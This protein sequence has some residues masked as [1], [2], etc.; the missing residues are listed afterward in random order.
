MKRVKNV[1]KEG[2]PFSHVSI[3]IPGPYIT[4][5]RLYD[6]LRG[7]LEKYKID[8]RYIELEITETSVIH[9]IENAI[10]AIRKF[11]EM[12][13][14]VALDD[15]GTGLSSLSYLKSMPIT[16]VKIDKSFVDG[17]PLSERD[18]AV[19]K[20]IVKLCYSLNLK[21]VIEG[22]ETDEQF[23]FITSLGLAKTP[24]I[25][26]YYFSRPLKVDELCHWIEER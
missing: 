22:V 24:D 8:S 23:D 26:G 21:V 12:G 5:T 18:S 25:Q 17:V 16:T 6:V 3:N 20:A 13:V 7:N 10:S 2:V 9:D 11:M 4:S 15:F 1:L 19:L 14:S